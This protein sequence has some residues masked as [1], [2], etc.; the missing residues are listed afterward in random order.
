LQ[1]KL[2]NKATIM[3]IL[4]LTN[5]PSPYMVDFFNE[6]GRHCDLTVL[7]EKSTSTERHKSWQDYRFKNFKGIVM[8]G[9]NTSVDKAFCPQVIKCLNKDFYDHIIV[10]NPAT[11]TGIM[12]IEYMKI[13]KIPFILES[14]GGF[15][16]EGNGLKERFKK[17]LMSGAKLYLSTTP[18]ADEYFLTYGA[19]KNKIVKFPFTSLHKKDLV[20]KPLSKNEKIAIRDKLGIKGRKVV[21]AVGS[22]IPRKNYDVL[23]KAWRMQYKDSTLY[24]IGGGEEEKHYQDLIGKHKLKNVYLLPFM[25]KEE[26]SEYYKASDLFIHPTRE[27][28]WGLVINEAMANGLPVITTEMCIAG[29]ELVKDDENGFILP[30]GGTDILAE[31]INLILSDDN[32]R[33]RMAAKSLVKIQWYTFENM[34]ASHIEIL[35]KLVK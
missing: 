32:L 10:T 27:D 34:A 24:L 4:F 25:G 17:H 1:I 7:F 11:P 28:I 6:L 9:V 15:A 21:T 30:V 16:K 22:F 12:A 26:L 20:E 18:K 29:L 31:K 3:K 23:I 13:K 5:V 19:P 2:I 8:R 14:E 33:E 35:A